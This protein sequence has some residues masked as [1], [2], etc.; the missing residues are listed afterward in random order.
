MQPVLARYPSVRVFY[1]HMRVEV[2]HARHQCRILL[3]TVLRA[4]P[5]WENE[6]TAVICRFP[7]PRS[8]ATYF[9]PALLK[10]RSPYTSSLTRIWGIPPH[11]NRA[12]IPHLPHRQTRIPPHSGNCS[13]TPPNKAQCRR[14]LSDPTGSLQTAVPLAT[15][16]NKSVFRY[17]L[18]PAD[19]SKVLA[20]CSVPNNPMCSHVHIGAYLCLSVRDCVVSP[21]PTDGAAN[22]V[23][24]LPKSC[25][26]GPY[27]RIISLTVHPDQNALDDPHAA[28]KPATESLFQLNFDY[29]FLAIPASNG[30][31]YMR[32]GTYFRTVE[33]TAV[34]I[35]PRHLRHAWL[36][37]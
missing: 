15:N 19:P 35:A 1:P 31:I 17:P 26:A 20:Y 27:A 37:V 16:R 14:W 29:D 32:A 22:T 33:F 6:F 34:L 11:Q 21:A 8:L 36:L 10:A 12:A 4:V 25:G 9:R 23:I 24:E 5:V 7:S 18:V 13:L 28:M 2:A 30:P 3:E